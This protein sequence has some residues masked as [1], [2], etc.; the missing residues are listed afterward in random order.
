[1][2]AVASHLTRPHVAPISAKVAKLRYS[3]DQEAGFSRR[4]HRHGFQYFDTGGKQVRDR[5]TLVRFEALK[6]PPAWK[7]VWI[8]RSPSNHLQATGRDARGRKQYRYHERWTDTRAGLKFD[9]TLEFAAILPRIRRRVQRDLNQSGLTRERG[10]ATVVR[11]LDRTL[12]RVGNDE[13]SRDNGSF[14]LTTIKDRHVAVRGAH[15][16]FRFHGKSGKLRDM[17]FADVRLSKI[18]R[19]CRDLSGEEL[20]QYVDDD[21]QTH[22]VTSSDVNLYLREISKHDFTAKDFRTW[23]ARLWRSSICESATRLLRRPPPNGM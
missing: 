8:S 17:Q 1:L 2:I 23:G 14:G 16:R 20:F 10:L 3:S 12:I 6:I 22:D 21:R 13:Y 11:L 15:L 5:Q 18:I 19:Q 9:L 7:E 4:P